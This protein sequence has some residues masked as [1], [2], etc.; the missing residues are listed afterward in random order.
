MPVTGPNLTPRA[1]RLHIN[2]GETFD[3]EFLP[4]PGAYRLRVMSFSNIL[5]SIFAR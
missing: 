3:F 1:A 2:P 4:K 5:M